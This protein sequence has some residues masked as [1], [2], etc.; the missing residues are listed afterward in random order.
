MPCG[1]QGR[2]SSVPPSVDD[3]KLVLATFQAA[4][5]LGLS[6]Q[7]IG[8]RPQPWA[9]FCRPVGPVG[10]RER[11]GNFPRR[12]ET[13]RVNPRLF[14]LPESFGAVLRLSEPLRRFRSLSECLG[15]SQ[16]L[17]ERLEK[18]RKRLGT[19]PSGS[20][21][22]GALRNLSAPLRTILRRSE[23]LGDVQNLF[24][25]LGTAWKR[26]EGFPAAR[27]ETEPFRIF[28]RLSE[29]F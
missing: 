24:A 9:R 26:S 10:M 1:L 27:N 29:R 19:I 5:V 25:R 16:N 17:S 6:S 7:G 11:S 2:E 28:P 18:D 23:R 8:L 13:F 14:E 21:G 22:F 20:E 4:R 15:A 12:S 3:V